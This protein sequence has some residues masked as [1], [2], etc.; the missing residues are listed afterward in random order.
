MAIF[1][2][3]S[4]SVALPGP[5]GDINEQSAI[6]TNLGLIS[7]LQ[8]TSESATATFEASEGTWQMLISVL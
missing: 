8:Y 5:T 1:T 3:S 2:T 6:F 7:L 4:F